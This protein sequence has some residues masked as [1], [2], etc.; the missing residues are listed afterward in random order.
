MIVVD[1]FVWDFPFTP[2]SAGI[3]AA[4]KITSISTSGL[5]GT[6]FHA[7]EE[8]NDFL[9]AGV[10]NPGSERKGVTVGHSRHK[11]RGS[12][13]ESGE[14]KTLS[15]Q[16][17]R[18][19]GVLPNNGQNSSASGN[20]IHCRL[21]LTLHVLPLPLIDLTN[22]HA[23]CIF[24]P[25]VRIPGSRVNGVIQVPFGESIIDLVVIAKHHTVDPLVRDTIL[26]TLGQLTK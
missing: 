11:H 25:G 22:R 24:P 10:S 21:S 19:G 1:R 8:N 26:Q 13:G 9:V 2:N 3:G 14:A 16:S 15:C 18:S 5:P 7:P 23:L 17:E 12:T 4:S 6:A 20:D